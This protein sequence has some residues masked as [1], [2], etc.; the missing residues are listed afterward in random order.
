MW[1]IYSRSLG[2]RPG[3]GQGIGG[4]AHKGSNWKAIETEK[5]AT[6]HQ[7]LIRGF[8]NSVSENHLE[9]ILERF[10][11]VLLWCSSGAEWVPLR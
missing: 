1:S 11:Q 4:R 10:L 8:P 9:N 2:E 7:H 5:T 6:D 3:G